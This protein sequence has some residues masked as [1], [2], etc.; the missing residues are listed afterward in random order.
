M[1]EFKPDRH[2]EHGHGFR[3]PLDD[4]SL[5]SE[6]IQE[7]RKLGT[8]GDGVGLLQYAAGSR[9][10]GHRPLDGRAECR[11]RSAALGE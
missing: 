7:L 4:S 2:H 6:D 1:G 9:Q 10:A 8:R 5:E 3:G 11:R